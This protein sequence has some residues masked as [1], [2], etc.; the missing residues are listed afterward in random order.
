LQEIIDNY[1]AGSNT[2]DADFAELVKFAQDLRKEE[3]RHVREGLSE[4]ELEIY[5]L[6]CKDKMT[7][8]EETKVRLA[9][10]VLLKRL[11][12]GHPKVL[13][14]DWF[15]DSQTR[16]AVR[17]EVGSVLDE[18][19]PDETYDRDLFAEKRD[20][21]FELTLDLAINQRKWAA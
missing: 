2:V 12:E 15:K 17:D 9:A 19:L 7:K 14:Q 10:K 3:E 20:K 18:Y 1:N 16:L 11:T 4:D 8:A 5:D 21:V 6:L 13:V